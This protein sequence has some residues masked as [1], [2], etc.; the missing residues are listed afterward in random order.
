MA[1]SL[2]AE[3]MDVVNCASMWRTDRSCSDMAAQTTDL[4]FSEKEAQS[5]YCTSSEVQTEV[6]Q[7][8]SSSGADMTKL[9]AWL[10]KITP[11]VIEELDKSNKSR[12]F[13]EYKLQESVDSSTRHLFSLSMPQTELQNDCFTSAIDWSS[14]GGILAVSRCAKEHPSWCVHSGCVSLHRTNGQECKTETPYRSLDVNAC[15]TALCAHPIESFILACGTFSGEVTVWNLQKDD[16]T[17]IGSITLHSEAVVHMQWIQNFDMTDLRPVL[18]SASRDGSVVIWTMKSTSSTLKAAKCFLLQAEKQS[19]DYGIV[20]A[21]FNPSNPGLFVAGI[22]G[23][24]VAL[25]TSD[26]RRPCL[27]KR[28]SVGHEL[29]Y[30]DPVLNILEGHKGTVTGVQWVPGSK[31]LFLS[32]GSDSELHVYSLAEV[33]LLRII[34]LPEPSYGLQVISS[35]P[36]VALTWGSSGAIHLHDVHTTKILPLLDLDDGNAK[37]SLSTV[38]VRTISSQ[39]LALGTTDGKVS[40]W[41]VPHLKFNTS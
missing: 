41:Q 18:A 40:V 39:L 20:C 34:H 3:D 32:C 25:C 27:R 14:T 35:H 12:A 9:A 5:K 7:E 1:N 29:D 36:S 23:G 11:R 8:Q 19:I 22:E 13:N 17:L 38:S 2:V 26:S 24:S 6:I 31:D 37:V 15:V 21:K 33:C 28:T 10:S 4:T 30:C 16:P